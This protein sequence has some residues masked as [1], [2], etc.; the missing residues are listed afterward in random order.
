[1][2][3]DD[4]FVRV[5]HWQLEQT[6]FFIRSDYCGQNLLEWGSSPE[7]AAFDLA[8]RISLVAEIA[9]AVAAAHSLGVLHNDLKPGNILVLSPPVAGVGWKIRISDFGIASLSRPQR[10]RDLQITYHQT[11]HTGSQTASPLGTVMYRAPE[12]AAGAAPSVSADVYAL[13][14]MLYQVACGDFLETP[15]PGWRSRI[16]D[17]LLQQDIADAANVDPKARIPNAADLSLRLRAIEARR[18]EQLARAKELAD[19]RRAQ[20]LLAAQRVRQPWIIATICALTLGLCASIWFY[21]RAVNA[22]NTAELQTQT[23]SAIY[24]FL[25]H[26]VLEQGDPLSGLPAQQTLLQ[27][28]DAA[29]AQIDRR[30]RNQPDIAGRLHE[31]IA[32]ALNNR[33]QFPPARQQYLLAA[34]CFRRAE[35]AQ[36]QSAIVADLKRESADIRGMQPGSLALATSSFAQTKNLVKA[37]PDPKPDVRAWFAAT[38]AGLMGSGAHPEQGIP[39]LNAALTVAARAPAASPRAILM[40]RQRLCYLYLRTGNGPAAEKTASAMIQSVLRL[41]GPESPALLFPE[42]N[43]QEALLIAGKFKDAIAETSRNYPHFFAQLGPANNMTLQTLATRAAAEGELQDYAA[44]TRDD[45]AVHRAAPPS[46]QLFRVGTLVDAATSECRAG[47]FSSGMDHA[48]EALRET[49]VPG[50]SE[51]FIGGSAFALSECILSS[52]ES[53]RQD[54]RSLNESEK[55]LK[56]MNIALTGHFMGNPGLAGNVDVAEARLAFDRGQYAAARQWADKAHPYFNGPGADA[57]EKQQLERIEQLL[58][59]IPAT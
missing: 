3:D 57:Y 4:R 31:T 14:I 17:P 53:S 48:R 25:S 1:M 56:S 42:L 33:S 59:K 41:D 27:A 37:L 54:P 40:L 7:F 9:D 39:I 50:T 47:R 21:I 23:A 24:G 12:L 18:E 38:Q 58:G 36:S 49:H 6:P 13:G 43:Y 5:A 2:A 32:D 20:E 35:G 22:R 8:S 19:H 16:P 28:L 26:D 52:F 44:A 30:F 15:S 11:V 46:D 45:L 10:L 29:A 55:L 34:R 51:A